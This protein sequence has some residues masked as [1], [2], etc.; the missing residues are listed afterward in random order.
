MRFPLK[1]MLKN[2]VNRMN[3]IK[4]LK[5][6]PHVLFGQTVEIRLYGRTKAAVGP[7]LDFHEL[8]IGQVVHGLLLEVGNRREWSRL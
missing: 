5:H 7:A 2:P 8:A 1:M 3:M 6:D 4:E